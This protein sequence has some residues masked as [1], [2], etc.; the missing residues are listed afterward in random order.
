MNTTS[1]TIVQRLWKSCN[2]LRDE[3][4]LESA[5]A[6]ESAAEAG[7]MDVKDENAR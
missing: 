7:L 4:R 5:R 2:V 1:S 3:R 6:V